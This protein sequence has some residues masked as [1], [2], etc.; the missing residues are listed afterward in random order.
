MGELRKAEER[1]RT[2]AGNSSDAGAGFRA[3]IAAQEDA[4][5]IMRLLL[6]TAEWF[7]GRGST[8]WQGLL[9]GE[10]SHRTVDAI[11]RG[12]VYAFRKGDAADIAGIVMLLREPSHWDRSLWG[13]EG[14][15]GAI[16]LHRLAVERAYAG[17]GL[18]ERIMRWVESEVRLPGKDRVRLDC[19]AGNPVLNDFYRRLGYRYAGSGE[20]ANGSYSKY[21]KPL[22]R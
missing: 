4:E 12:D 3:G 22:A 2:H 17:E 16:Y 18:G 8:Q 5:E 10:D 7:R 20:I 19:L 6:R 14:H 1:E 13:E 11:A 21:E 15:E 9:Y